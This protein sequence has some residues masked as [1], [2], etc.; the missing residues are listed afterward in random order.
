MIPFFYIGSNKLCTYCGDPPTQLDH[1]IPVSYQTDI[2]VPQGRLTKFGPLAHSCRSCN[3][4]LGNKYFST[5]QERCEF[6]SNAIDADTKP[7]TWSK[8]ELKELDYSLQRYVEQAQARRLWMRFRSDWYQS[9]DYLL[10]IERIAW[11]PCLDRDSKRYNE[12][13]FNYFESTIEWL[14]T[15]TWN[16]RY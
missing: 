9:R 3:T 14:K 1:V 10:N 13:M 16:S 2:P 4:T 7:V 8:K 15:L 5:F 11:E 6:A 12:K